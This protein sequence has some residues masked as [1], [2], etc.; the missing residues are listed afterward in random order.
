VQT[1]IRLLFR[2][3]FQSLWRWSSQTA[4]LF[5]LPQAIIADMSVLS[6]LFGCFAEL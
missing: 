6:S 2:M 5:W 1:S 3:S 4:I